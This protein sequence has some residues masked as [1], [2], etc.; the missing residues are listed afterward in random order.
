MN[1]VVIITCI[2]CLIGT[3][4]VGLAYYYV[5]AGQQAQDQ[6]TPVA[7][8]YR[9]LTSEVQISGST[10][11]E[12]TVDLSFK[13][14]G[15][16]DAV[17]VAVG[18]TVST[19][20]VLM[21]L[22][23]TTITDQVAQAQAN[24]AV[25]VAKL[26]DLQNGTRPE[27]IAVTQAELASDTST[28]QSAQEGLVNALTR[29]QSTADVAIRFTI[30]QF[31]TN[32]TMA[33][34]QF[35]I[36]VSDS[37][38]G[39]SVLDARRAIAADLASWSTRMTSLQQAGADDLLAAGAS[40][41]GYLQSTS[42][43]LDGL[44]RILATLN[45]VQFATSQAAVAAARTGITTTSD[46]LTTATEQVHSAQDAITVTERQLALEKAGATAQS[47][48]AQRAA[49]D[50]ARAQLAELQNELQDQEITA[51]FDGI[52]TAVNAKQGETVSAGDPVVSE[53]SNGQLKVEGFVPEIHYG[54]IALGQPV[55]IQLDAFPGMAF[56]GTLG[57]ID[58]SAVLQD[59]VPNFK[60]TVYFTNP[61]A[62]IKP[63]LTAQAFIQTGDKENALAIPLAAVTGSGPS[64]TVMRLTGSTS[65]QVHVVLGIVGTDGYVEVTSGLTQGDTVLVNETKQY[66][67]VPN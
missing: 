37:Q 64:A 32:P 61:D 14:G 4:G 19:K 11:A 51:P 46:A 2:V 28:L 13:N 42:G 6:L 58:P 23:S 26:R 31:I 33:N 50:S 59:G 52:I 16:V 56:P 27:Q 49:V 63:G 41:Q 29:A 10:K 17:P 9:H 30:D 25:Q 12:S 21:S 7:A 67:A 43:I 5:Q 36:P 45:S 20:T 54:D 44:I 66:R 55:R 8:A 60:V 3:G 39:L 62:R 38:L 35:T 34:S 53:I 18:D 22:R 57:R 48:A 1:R 15:I 24:L 47:I 65:E 40:M